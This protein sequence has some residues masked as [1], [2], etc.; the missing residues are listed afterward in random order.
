[1]FPTVV[2][3]TTAQKAI[4]V[5]IARSR[6]GVGAALSLHL[7]FFPDEPLCPDCGGAGHENRRRCRTCDGLGY[8]TSVSTDREVR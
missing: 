3:L 1:M 2:P 6:W 5:S 8:V 7:L 4:L